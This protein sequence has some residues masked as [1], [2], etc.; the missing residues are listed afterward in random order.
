MKFTLYASQIGKSLPGKAERS[1]QCAVSVAWPHVPDQKPNAM[2]SGI[3]QH[4]KQEPRF[5]R[6]LL[7]MSTF[8]DTAMPPRFGSIDNRTGTN[9]SRTGSELFLTYA[10]CTGCDQWPMLG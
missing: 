9:K 7:P 6:I 3:K 5:R 1:L 10:A 2:I 8:P 4:D